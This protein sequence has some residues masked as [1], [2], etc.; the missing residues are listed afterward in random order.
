[1]LENV[2]PRKVLEMLWASGKR[3]A[4]H[5]EREGTAL[6]SA[7]C[8]IMPEA[9]SATAICKSKYWFLDY[10]IGAEQVQD[11]RT[12][13]HLK[14]DRLLKLLQNRR[15]TP[16]HFIAIKTLWVKFWFRQDV[17]GLTRSFSG[18]C[19]CPNL[20]MPTNDLCTTVSFAGLKV[21]RS[22]KETKCITNYA[23]TS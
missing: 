22:R 13:R 2:W 7:L 21:L 9:G 20:F 8:Q 16:F 1:M 6:F 17:M 5:E 12:T 4:V 19:H 10:Q 23:F 11:S 15:Y 18:Q 3:D 14:S